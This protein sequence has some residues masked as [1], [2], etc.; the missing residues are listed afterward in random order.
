LIVDLL[1][2][3]TGE[4]KLSPQRRLDLILRYLGVPRTQKNIATA[5]GLAKKNEG[6]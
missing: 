4:K 3:K 5:E 2:P 6:L 1:N